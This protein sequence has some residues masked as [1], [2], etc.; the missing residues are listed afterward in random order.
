MYAEDALFTLTNLQI[1]GVLTI[2]TCLGAVFVGLVILIARGAWPMRLFVGSLAAL[3]F[4]WLSPQVF[5]EYYRVIIPN[6][7]RQSVLG[8]PDLVG[9]LNVISFRDTAS[10]SAHGRGVFYLFLLIVSLCATR[11]CRRNAA[12]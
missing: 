9:F 5:Y 1:T 4:E 8:A 11:R 10:L 3:A 6:L 7:P 2:A 12:N